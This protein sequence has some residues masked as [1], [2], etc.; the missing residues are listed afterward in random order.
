MVADR[1]GVRLKNVFSESLRCARRAKNASV[2]WLRRIGEV[3]A[4][5]IYSLGEVRTVSFVRNLE[6]GRDS[7]EVR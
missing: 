4:V 3:R 1:E 6:L 5:G 7:L 2:R